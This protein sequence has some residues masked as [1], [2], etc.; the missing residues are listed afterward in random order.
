MFIVFEG[1]DGSGKGTQIEMLRKVLESTG[2]N[3]V[4]T[5]EPGGTASGIILRSMVK[6]DAEIES[7]T[8]ELLFIADRTENIA[9]VVKPALSEK[10]IVISDRSYLTG[11]AY[12]PREEWE[13]LMPLYKRAMD[14]VEIDLCINLLIKSETFMSRV[15]GRDG[16]LDEREKL[17]EK[18]FESFQNNLSEA[19]AFSN[20]YEVIDI[21][22]EGMPEEVHKRIFK[23]VVEKYL[24]DM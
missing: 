16:K 6:E 8:R 1:V 21:D 3:V 7:F 18:N 10:K 13:F 17:V 22:G 15:L 11:L 20:V 23:G 24:L 9:K 12:A 14:G 5:K 19:C 2:M 4:L